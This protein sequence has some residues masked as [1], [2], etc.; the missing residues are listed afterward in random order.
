MDTDHAEY[1]RFLTAVAA[2]VDPPPIYVIESML[3]E[4]QQRANVAVSAARTAPELQ[5][6]ADAKVAIVAVLEAKRA[7][8]LDALRAIE[9]PSAGVPVEVDAAPPKPKRKRRTI[10][11]KPKIDPEVTADAG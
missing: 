10:K 5:A 3:E 1:E 9:Q 7:E 2:T 6:A 11:K 8:L 4:A